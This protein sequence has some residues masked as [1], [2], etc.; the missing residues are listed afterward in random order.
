[1]YSWDGSCDAVA[2]MEHNEYTIVPGDSFRCQSDAGIVK[3]V[4]MLSVLNDGSLL[5]Y[6]W[7]IDPHQN[8]YLPL[9]YWALMKRE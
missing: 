6:F 4:Q 3:I 7:T 8:Y 1:M 2:L 5:V 9:L